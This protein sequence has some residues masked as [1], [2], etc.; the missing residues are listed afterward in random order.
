PPL[1][2]SGDASL[3][4]EYGPAMPGTEITPETAARGRAILHEMSPPVVVPVRIPRR[5]ATGRGPVRLL[6]EVELTDDDED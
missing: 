2:G 4:L 6:L 3:Q 1:A 5:L